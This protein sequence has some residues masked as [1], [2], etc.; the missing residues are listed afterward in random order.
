MPRQAA[1]PQASGNGVG[2]TD[3][4]APNA[5]ILE[6]PERLRD[7]N[8]IVLSFL[9][10]SIPATVP[11]AE[12]TPLAG[13]WK[14]HSSIAGHESDFDCTFTQTNQDLGGTC[15]TNEATLTI[16]GKVEASKVTFQ[17][18]TTYEGQELTIVH[19]GKIESPAKFAGSVEVQPMGVTGDF[20]A[21]QVK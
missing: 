17:Y 8:T 13:Q 14:M 1:P 4:V 5:A 10:F 15:K 11:A 16:S 18:K 2:Y 19:S 3:P 7:V 12:D 6:V 20:T 9:L 21:S